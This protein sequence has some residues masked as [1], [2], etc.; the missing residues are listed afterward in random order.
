MKTL[1]LF[2]RSLILIFVLSLLPNKCI[3]QPNEIGSGIAINFPSTV[4]SRVDLGDV[5]NSVNFPLTIEAWIYPT[6]WMPSVY[7]PVMASDNY[8]P[9]GHY[10]G[11]WLRFNTSGNLIFEIGD[12]YGAGS[13]DRRGKKT[14]GVPPLNAWTHIAVVAISVN[15][16]NF[17]FNG[18]L[19]STVDTDG[20]AINTT[21][22][23]SSYPAYIG[24]QEHPAAEVNF[25]GNLDEV[26]LWDI[27]RSESE[28]RDKMC[29]K[30]TGL[31]PGLIGNWRFDE[32]Y[33]SSTV[34]DYSSTN[35]DG[36]VI[37]SAVKMTSGAPIGDL[38]VLVYS[39]DYLGVTLDLNSIGGDHLKLSNITNVPFGMH[40]YRVDQY[41]YS[42]TGLQEIPEYYYGVF[43]ANDGIT[44]KYS[45]DYS[46]SFSNGVVV[47]ENESSSKLYK[48]LNNSYDIWNNSLS[49]LF[50]AANKIKKKKHAGDCEFVFTV[51]SIT[52]INIVNSI[53]GNNAESYS[54]MV[55][56]NPSTES[57][58]CQGLEV[59]TEFYIINTLG[60]EIFRG[61]PLQTGCQ[62]DVSTY[63]DGTYFLV[64]N[65]GGVVYKTIIMKQ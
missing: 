10:Y 33:V 32:S 47:P 13:S 3:G 23:H 64:Q 54:L 48:R 16:I 30:L 43:I 62:I 65:K 5:Y 45:L 40:L 39:D 11:F 9:G 41:P 61:T 20:G 4:G 36:Y 21:I 29:E 34:A 63:P 56:P 53:V 6:A 52:N 51:D 22:L 27:A 55:Y 57:I 17:Y 49:T 8:G 50:I 19:Q 2:F 38:S 37:G 46:Y 35:T 18:V 31:E 12:G 59:D 60:E 26:R 24:C 42:M 14:I 1:R 15:D 7:S 25:T 58:I 28:I 44:A